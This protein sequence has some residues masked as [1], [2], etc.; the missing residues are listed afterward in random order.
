MKSLIGF[1]LLLSCAAFPNLARAQTDIPQLLQ[2]LKSSDVNTRIAAFYKIY[3]TPHAV[4]KPDVGR[5]LVGLL[6]LEESVYHSDA[7]FVGGEG[8]ANYYGNL[9][10]AV[11]HYVQT[12]GDMR[13]VPMLID[14]PSNAG[15]LYDLALAKFGDRITA[16]LEAAEASSDLPGRMTAIDIAAIQLRWDHAGIQPLPDVRQRLSDLVLAALRDHDGGIRLSAIMALETV[17]DPAYL[18]ALD[19]VAQS[20]PD[21]TVRARAKR[22]DQA[23]REGRGLHIP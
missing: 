18:P 1:V 16:P 15:S 12:T 4:D 2:E 11:L 5:A 19:A 3:A 10:D 20:D 22:A 14:E 6:E 7:P 9:S 13:P 23:I 21:A 17:G 8:Y